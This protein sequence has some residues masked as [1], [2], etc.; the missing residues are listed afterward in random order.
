MSLSD[1]PP[2]EVRPCADPN[3]AGTSWRAEKLKDLVWRAKC[4]GV[5]DLPA[6]QALEREMRDATAVLDAMAVE[7]SAPE[8]ARPWWKDGEYDEA[9][10]EAANDR[11]MEAYAERRFRDAHAA[12]TE[13]ARL[14]PRRAGYHANR[15]AVSLKLG[16]HRAAAEDAENALLFDEAH[17]KAMLRFGEAA[18]RGR[19]DP[20]RA[21]ARFRDARALSLIHI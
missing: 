8:Y 13:A 17:V 7:Q 6:V 21:L 4:L 12:F 14:E 20:R 2:H 10:A 11:G 9:R 18:L 5:R 1:P 19:L 3:D 15:A 16:A